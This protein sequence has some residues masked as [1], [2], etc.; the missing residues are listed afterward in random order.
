MFAVVAG[1]LLGLSL[2]AP[3]G[4]MNALIAREA[5]ARGM[6]SGLRVGMGAPVADV[7]WLGVLVWGLGDFIS[8]TGLRIAAIAGSGVMAY[9]AVDTWRS[10]D[11]K[12]ADRPATFWA[13][14]VAAMTNPYQA[15]WWLSGGF[16]FVQSQGLAAVPGFLAGIFGWV[17]VFSF[18]VAHGA[19]RWT[20]FQNGVRVAATLLLAVFS[21]ALLGEATGRL[22]V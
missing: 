5:G 12:A 16:V 4:P 2:A 10:R 9:F 19:Q 6:A 17:L 7:V 11:P 8:D 15:A 21:V 13:G 14:F 20:G 22:S 1:F 18:L 3:P